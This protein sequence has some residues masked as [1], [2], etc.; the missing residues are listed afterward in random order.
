M[1]PSL[2]ETTLAELTIRSGNAIAVRP[3]VRIEIYHG[4]VQLDDQPD[5]ASV[6]AF[7]QAVRVAVPSLTHY[8]T[9]T[10]R[11]DA[12]ATE[13]AWTVVPSF[14]RH[15]KDMQHVWV[16][17]QTLPRA[18]DVPAAALEVLVNFERP[19]W[20]AQEASEILERTRTSAARE[21]PWLVGGYK[22][23]ISLT[24]PVEH[25]LVSD[26]GLRTWLCA[27][28]LLRDGHFVS[29]ICAPGL[30][31]DAELALQ[32]DG[33]PS[34]SAPNP[35]IQRPSLRPRVNDAL[36]MLLC[37]DAASGKAYPLVPRIEWLSFLR[38]ESLDSPAMPANWRE[39]L[40][41]H[42]GVR[43]HDLNRGAVCVESGSLRDVTAWSPDPSWMAARRHAARTLRPIRVPTLT[44][45]AVVGLP[46]G[47]SQAWLEVYDSDKPVQVDDT[48][49]E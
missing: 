14:V 44:P 5:Y 30:I 7:I 37:A 1:R 26:D 29:A 28:P 2:D 42:D 34:P 39:V 22:T 19:S 15:A 32:R 31:G 12:P 40:E 4:G 46:Y 23:W 27:Q 33:F 20:S 36:S 47:A 13:V 21:S 35:L 18:S 3:C 43:V 24:L 11:K 48:S 16:M 41:K 38:A 17:Y 8:R 49:Y 6:D 25:P 45:S 10:L 9:A